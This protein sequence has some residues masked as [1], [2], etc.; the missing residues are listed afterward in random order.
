MAPE[1]MMR[2]KYTEVKT[3]PKYP[4]LT[5][6]KADVYSYG[7]VMYELCTRQEPYKGVRQMDLSIHIAVENKRPPIPPETPQSLG[8]LMKMCWSAEPTE[9]YRNFLEN[10]NVKTFF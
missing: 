7:L 3:P 2:Q 9:R 4:R 8:E 1:V 5:L 10:S 6:Q